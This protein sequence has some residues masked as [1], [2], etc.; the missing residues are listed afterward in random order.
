MLIS[1]IPTKIDVVW[2]KNA[3]GTYVRTVPDTSVDPNAASWS[4][5]FPPNTFVPL[6]SGGEPPDGRDFNGGLKAISAWSQWF[7]A[8]GPIKY[9]S[10]F[11]AT[12]TGYPLGAVVLDPSNAGM[13]WRNTIDGNTNT[14]TAGSGGTGWTNFFPQT[15]T[16]NSGTASKWAAPITVTAAGDISGNVSFDGSGNATFTMAYVP[17]S[18]N[19]TLASGHVQLGT[20]IMN[21]V[22]LSGPLTEQAYSI[23][24][25]LA[26]PNACLNVQCT[27]ENSVSTNAIDYWAQ[28]VSFNTTGAT[29]YVQRPTA[30]GAVASGLYAFAIGF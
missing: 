17:Q 12:I 7:Q 2:A 20:L 18:A 5:G 30:S 19:Y 21:W 29:L 4:L 13:Y 9:D 23:A 24:W 6:A 11:Q 27:I 15:I 25:D 16:G 14:L 26:F 3:T 28:V 8:G 1:N 22:R 10:T